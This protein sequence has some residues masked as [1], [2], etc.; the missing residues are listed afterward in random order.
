MGSLRRLGLLFDKKRSLDI[1]MRPSDF[2]TL[3]LHP[4]DT[5]AHGIVVHRIDQCC[6]VV[7]QFQ[8]LDT[9]FLH[10]TEILL[11]GGCQTGQHTHRRL[12]DVVQCHH[13][14][15]LADACL[16]DTHFGLLIQQPNRKGYTNLRIIRTR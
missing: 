1:G 9:L 5:T 6:R 16:K 10:R 15:R 2:L 3:V 14:T 12:Y 8:L 4:A 7:H 11:M 13:L